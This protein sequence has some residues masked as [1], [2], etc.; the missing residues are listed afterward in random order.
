MSTDQAIQHRV[1]FGRRELLVLVAIVG[2]FVAIVV[3]AI[4]GA[5]ETMGRT[6]CQCHGMQLGLGIQNFHDIRKEIPP[7]YLT[8]DHSP[9]AVPSGHAT[10]SVLI[11]P[12][13]E[14]Q[15]VFDLADLT[16]P[17]DETASP[18]TDH[19]TLLATNFATYY[20]P[21]RGR[22][23]NAVAL[24][25]YG[26]VSLAVATPGVVRAEPRTWDGAMLP[27]RVFNASSDPNAE[28]LAGFPPGILKGGEYRSMTTFA[29]VVDGL[30]NTAFL[31]EKAVRYGHFGGVKIDFSKVVLAEEQDGPLYYG[32]G[33]NPG[34]QAA[35]GAIAFWSRRLAPVPGQRLIAL[36]PR[37]E[38]PNNR[39][40]SWHPGVTLFLL[41]DGS[42]RSVSNATSP[43][44][45]QRLGSRNDS[46][47]FS[48]P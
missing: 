1:W 38:P 47:T 5:R 24:G 29:S 33:G 7:S 10:W 23:V 17:L 35:P 14:Q 30:S 31:G 44:A 28:E 43:V 3:P 41:G 6:S 27:S 9:A 22:S 34:D 12:F 18:P 48:L 11:M 39:F 19:R 42:I 36:K 40:G 15:N 8:N 45:L 4:Q 2:M 32:R 21:S 25:D 20:C 13:M 26:C 16:V 46:Q 37:E